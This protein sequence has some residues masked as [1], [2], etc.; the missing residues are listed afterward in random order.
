[1]C[2]AGP[3]I[4]LAWDTCTE[5]GVVAVCD[6]TRVLAGSRFETLKGHAGWLMPL[7]D[8]A[9]R[10]AGKTPGDVSVVAAGTGPGGYTGVKVGVSTAKAVAI[11][12]GVG[13]IG[14]PALDLLAAHAP[15]DGRPVLACLD[16]RQG[17]VYAA[18][19][20]CGGVRHKRLTEYV[21]VR[22]EEAGGMAAGLGL[23][24][25]V[26]IGHVPGPA[27]D[28]ALEAGARLSKPEALASGFPSGGVLAAMADE[29]LRRG[30]AK[31]AALV[32]PIYL[33]KPV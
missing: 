27:V 28:A 10:A 18:C 17:L 16:A 24:D 33:K 12:L 31:D 3:G 25:V 9:V 23:D 29:M 6:G 30:E 1:M 15:A 20:S 32:N 5:Q 4:V 26:A 19:Y 22:P 14:V 7:L 2:E 21:C 13:L 8:S 11:A